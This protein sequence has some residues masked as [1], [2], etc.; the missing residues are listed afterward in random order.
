MAE[1]TN[2][3]PITANR[4]ALDATAQAFLSEMENSNTVQANDK[5]PKQ[6]ATEVEPETSEQQ[7]NQEIDDGL[8]FLNEESDTEE[9][10][11]EDTTE[12]EV[13]EEIDNAPRVIDENDLENYSVLTKV[14]GEEKYLPLNE[15]RKGYQIDAVNTQKSQSLAE[16]KKLL[17]QREDELSKVIPYLNDAANRYTQKLQ[18][19]I[20]EPDKTLE[21]TDPIKYNQQVADY[22]MKNQQLQQAKE[23][24]KQ[25]QELAQ[26]QAIKQ[27]QERVQSEY[28]KLQD[29][30]PHLK[31]PVKRQ[32]ISKEMAKYAQEIGYSEAEFSQLYDHRDATTLFKAMQ[33]D[34]LMARKKTTLK[35]VAQKPKVGTI[36]SSA[37]RSNNEIG[38]QRYKDAKARLKKTG[39]I[40]DAAAV[41]LS[42]V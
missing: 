1:Q 14:N 31:D 33:F 21:Q 18:S 15:I 17:Q 10:P 32:K 16:E 3:N 9:A 7:A 39:D 20:I 37:R 6:P 36:K 29:R 11:L 41:F 42:H 22:V 26:Q 5:Q 38:Q 40:K 23:E 28:I 27:H 30:I 4:D 8:E 19:E 2:G 35:E 12:A 34:R 24:A 25:A 13:T